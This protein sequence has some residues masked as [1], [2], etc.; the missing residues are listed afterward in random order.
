MQ[1]LSLKLLSRDDKKEL[2]RHQGEVDTY[3]FL[4]RL[5][6][7]DTKIYYGAVKRGSDSNLRDVI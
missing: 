5:G 2:Q 1:L 4:T 6:A 7:N 3:H